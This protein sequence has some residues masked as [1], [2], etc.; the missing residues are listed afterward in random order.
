MATVTVT[1][2]SKDQQGRRTRSSEDK[3]KQATSSP[4]KGAIPKTTG[5]AT[6]QRIN[7][8]GEVALPPDKEQDVRIHPF[9]MKMR[10]AKGM[11]TRRMNN[12]G[13]TPWI[14][15]EEVSCSRRHVVSGHLR[16]V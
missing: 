16:G 5:D 2:M 6:P 7:E 3:R 8:F 11:L 9:V 14:F 1:E 10:S 12:A 15:Y 13:K 4:S